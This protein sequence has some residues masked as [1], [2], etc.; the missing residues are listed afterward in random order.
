MARS[1]LTVAQK[2]VVVAAIVTVFLTLFGWFV[3]WWDG[4]FTGLNH[5]GL[6]WWAALLCLIVLFVLL[7][8]LTSFCCMLLGVW[9]AYV[10]WDWW[11]IF[12]VSLYMP[13]IATFIKGLV[14]SL[15]VAVFE[16]LLTVV[17][18]VFGN[19]S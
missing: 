16:V 7:P 18:I 1:N 11:F 17:T 9:T 19:K 5:F 8:R 12:A 2:V 13:T 4:I 14:F 10:L 3:L 15:I 6:P